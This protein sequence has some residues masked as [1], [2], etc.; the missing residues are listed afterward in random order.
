MGNLYRDAGPKCCQHS[1]TSRAQSPLIPFYTWCN[2]F[3]TGLHYSPVVGIPLLLLSNSFIL[4]LHLPPL[5]RELG[6]IIIIIIAV[7]FPACCITSIS[8]PEIIHR[9]NKVA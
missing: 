9:R 4:P 6:A 1:Q 5:A 7:V 2:F 8:E 3:L